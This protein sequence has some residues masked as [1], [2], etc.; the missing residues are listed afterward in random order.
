MC[1]GLSHPHGVRRRLLYMGQRRNRRRDVHACDDYDIHRDRYRCQRMPEHRHDNHN[2]EPVADGGRE[3]ERDH[4]MCRRFCDPNGVR[5]RFLCWDNG[6]TDG[7]AFTPAATTT[8]TVTGT[9]ANGCQNTDTITI[10]VNPLPTVVANATATTICAGDPVTLTGSGADSYTW[11]NGATDGVA[12]TPAATTTYTVTGTDANGCQNTDTI[13]ITVNPNPTIT[14]TG[15]PTC[16]TDLS[17]YSLTVS[18]SS[19]TLSSTEGTVTN[20]GGNN[21]TITGI[22][23]GNDVTLNVLDA[24]GC[25]GTLPVTAPDCSCPVVDAPTGGGDQQYCAGSAIP[26]VSASVNPGETVDWYDAPTGGTLLLADDT[27][28]T[29]TGAGTYY[30]QARNTTTGCTSGTRTGIT[31]TENP[32]PTVVANANATTICAGDPVTLTGSGAGSYSWDNGATDGVAFTPAATTTYTVTGTDANGCQNTDT[33]TITVNPLPTVVAN[34]TATTICAGDPVTLTGSGADSY[35]WDNGATDGVAFTPAATTTYTVTGTDA[36][37]CQNTDTI[38]IT[39]NPNPTITITGAPTCSTDLSTYSL[40]VSVSS[41]TLS[42][43]EGTVTN[44]GGNN[45]TITGITSGNDVTLNV[46]DA[47]GCSGTLP[48]TAPDCS[49]PVVDA[50]T[51]GGDQQ[52][53][54]GSAIPDVSASVNPGETVDWYDAPTG[55]T[56]LLADD[57]DYTPTG[58]GTYY[59]QARN[60]TTGCTSGTRTGITVTENPLPTVVANANATTICAGDPVT[61]TGSGAGS[62]SWD[63]GATD[64]VAFTPAATTTYTVTGT[65]ANG[66]QNTDTITITVNPLPTVVANA[67]ATTICAGDPVTLTGSGADSYT[68]DNGATDGVAFTPAATTTYTVTGTD[69]NGCQN[70]DTIT[71]TVNPNPTITI[72]GAPTCSTDLSTYSLTVSVSSGTL[73]STEGTVTNTGGNN[74]TITG[75][76]SGNDVTLNV[77]DANGCSGTLP[78]TAPDCS[79]PV[80]DAPTGGGD[81]QYCAGSAI[82]DVS[83]SV[84]PGETVDWYDAP[85]GGTLLLADDTDY[86]PTGAGT[87][88]AQARNTTTGCTSGTRTGITVTENPLPT[89]V[90]NAN[91]TTICAGDPV[92]LTGSGAGSYS[93]DN[94]ATDGVA[95]TPAAT[96]TYTVTGT[97]ANGC[98]NTDTITITVNPLP[99]V[100]ANATATTICA[101][102]PVTLTGSGAD[103]YTWDNG[104]TDGVAFTPA[105]TTTYTVT[106]TD[107]NGCQ[108][109]DTITITVNPNPTITITGAPTCSTDLSTYSLTVSVSSGTLS[110]T[111]G[112]VTNTGGN[113]WTITGI[114]SGND[115]TL[116]VLDANG[117]SGTLPVTAPDCSCPVVDAPVSGG[118]R[119]ECEQN[120]MPDPDRYRPHRQRTQP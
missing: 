6:A 17:T 43:T 94:G 15:A 120:P 70:T 89:V 32:L 71:I 77:L 56:L 57:T 96:T 31:V 48:V 58:A 99:T 20:T 49:C 33:I 39:V 118:D 28:Y 115:V 23:S 82:P 106:G 5:R 11:D 53:C 4:D 107:A 2:R 12:F 67:T 46:L 63:N 84:N 100:V 104:A 80:V 114:T 59:A 62:Y 13:T 112:T 21:W 95:F 1:R 98:Q 54:A 83:A 103:S 30:A 22:T 50:P 72:T 64:G 75:I 110:S 81:Q 102:D 109:T 92:T 52:Y 108:N 117:C 105:A 34:A 26:D 97:D 16:S 51:G 68:W 45:W 76:T 35:T 14:I 36:N 47:N 40:T 86:T 93:W 19:G 29:P 65:D 37:G 90:A 69:A 91:A 10:T 113:N 7:V 55:G 87:Y 42:S 73:S 27:D 66:C 116:N 3:R 41:G 9:D 8:Y 101:G 25:S 61:L 85:T 24:N 44:T 38:T 60:T 119:T 88:Y 74:W 111:E 78:V 18:V 79:C